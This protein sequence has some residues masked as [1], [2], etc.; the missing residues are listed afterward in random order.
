MHPTLLKKFTLR[1]NFNAGVFEVY[2]SWATKQGLE[3]W[4]LRSADFISPEGKTRAP[5]ELAQSGDAYTWKW[6]GF[7][8]EISE[9]RK[10]LEA[11]GKDFFKFTFSGNCIV[12]ISIRTE[13]ETTV[14]ELTQE[15]I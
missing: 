3:N 8:D 2:K 9:K 13:K 10:V 12:S 1:A 15:N 7:P 4:F 5:L 11:N 14:V 6:H